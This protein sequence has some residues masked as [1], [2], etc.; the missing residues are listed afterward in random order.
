M[1]VTI[2]PKIQYQHI[3][4]T[5]EHSS[6]FEY[7]LPSSATGRNRI[8]SAI[9]MQINLVDIWSLFYSS[10]YCATSH[11]SGRL[12]SYLPG[13]LDGSCCT[14]RL[15]GRSAPRCSTSGNF[16][17]DPI[18]P[19][20]SHTLCHIIATNMHFIARVETCVVRLSNLFFS[21]ASC[22]TASFFIHSFRQLARNVT[23]EAK[24][25]GRCLDLYLGGHNSLRPG[26]TDWDQSCWSSKRVRPD[27]KLGQCLLV[28]KCW[29]NWREIR[30]RWID[31][32]F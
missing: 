17:F 21:R 15:H 20:N 1:S 29:I 4:C 12:E 32:G 8:P 6:W 22:L 16:K 7:E 9:S 2:Y 19:P 31:W 25:Q 26:T 11:R 14:L 28:W 23:L 10:L 13:D 30:C 24:L 18:S 3:Y 27:V 5:Y